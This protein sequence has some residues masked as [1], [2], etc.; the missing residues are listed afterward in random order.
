VIQLPMFLTARSCRETI[1]VCQAIQ[2][3]EG[4]VAIDAGRLRF[5]DPFG[6]TLLGASFHDLQA[7]KQRVFVHGLTADVGGYL[8]RMD[9]FEGIEL[10]NC[11][12]AGRRRDRQDS[13]VELTCIDDRN[14]ASDAATR[15][16]NALIGSVPCTD[17][18]ESADEMA[19][20]TESDRLSVLIQY[21]LSEL[22]ENA[23]THARRAGRQ[24]A[25]VWIAGQYYPT[26]DLVR[27]AVTDNG[28]G[29]L[30]TLRD[31]PLLRRQTHRD[32][33]LIAMR[34]RV[35]CNRDLGIHED[36]VNQGVGLTT[37]VRIAQAAEG[38]ALI[39]SGNAYHDPTVAGGL[40]PEGVFW[41]G[42]AVAL[43][44]SR[45]KLGSVRIPA[46]LPTLGAV[47][48]VTIRFE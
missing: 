22:L 25:R 2:D 33:I 43:E 39:V 6:L 46:L 45:V 36:T 9:L 11:A 48:P 15:L 3:A 38:R 40:L 34:P 1:A 29:F 16:V 28:C 7:W 44:I 30:T 26:K 31:H 19:G 47:P 35:S 13:L 27:L 10:R 41:Q 21:L 4:D 37:V 23:V 5:V 8:Q 17:R 12:P 14:A 20:G 18:S 24:N 42:V 32:A